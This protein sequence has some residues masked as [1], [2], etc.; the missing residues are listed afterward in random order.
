MIADRVQRPPPELREAR[1]AD[2]SLLFSAGNIAI[3]VLAPR[4]RAEAHGGAGSACRSTSRA[5][6]SRS[7]G[8]AAARREVAGIKFETFVFDALVRGRTPA[9]PRGPARGRVRPDQERVRRGLARDVAR[10]PVRGRRADARGGRRRASRGT[11]PAHPR[12]ADRDLSALR[13]RSREELRTR[14]VPARTRL[15]RAPSTWETPDMPALNRVAVL[16]GGIVLRASRLAEERAPRWSGASCEPG[17]EVTPVV[18]GKDGDVVAPL[19]EARRGRA[20]EGSRRRVS[21]G[22]DLRHRRSRSTMELIQQEV[23]VVVIGLHGPGGEDGTIQGFLETAGLAYTG[24]G[25][26]DLRARDG[27]GAPEAASCAA[28]GL[29]TAD[30]IDLGSP[31]GR[32][33]R[34]RRR[35][36]AGRGPGPGRRGYPVVVKARTLGSSVGVGF[37]ADHA[38]LDAS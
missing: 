6:S 35:A 3:H 24:P 30:W 4:L 7:S 1:D 14:L 34:S 15:R 17:F 38:A 21:Q 11:R 29:P 23:Q 22:R 19:G 31:R 8:P 12:V 9:R 18:I 5:R 20:A 36:T 27:Q 25:R 26:H 2:G 37:A 16:C 32:E 13:G 33:P 28:A 10:A